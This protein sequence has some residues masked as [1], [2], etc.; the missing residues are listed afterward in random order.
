MGTVE[1]IDYAYPMMMAE[2]RL[3]AAHDEL[4]H[5]DMA[6]GLEELTQA[7][8]ETRLAAAAVRHMMEK[9]T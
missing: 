5:G 4:L 2:N 3:K 8:V 6:K 7:V 9:R 1:L